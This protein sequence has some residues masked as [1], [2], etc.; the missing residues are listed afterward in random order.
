MVA[1]TRHDLK[2]PLTAICIATDMLLRGDLSVRKKNRLLQQIDKSSNRAQRM[3]ADLLELALIRVGSGIDITRSPVELHKVV[4]QCINELQL[5][6][7]HA[8]LRRQASGDR[9]T[10]LDADRIQQLVS[11][12]MVNNVVY[13]DP[14]K[15]I[16]IASALVNGM[17]K[18]TVQN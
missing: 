9:D 6:F 16:T 1:I 10:E 3:I 14:Q 17:A 11:N 13:V 18:V 7:P 5:A 8:T 15:A 4:S 2:K 12:L